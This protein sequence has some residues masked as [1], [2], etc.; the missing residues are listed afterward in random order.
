MSRVAARRPSRRRPARP[1][2][3]TATRQGLGPPGP[4]PARERRETHGLTR[5]G[6][7]ARWYVPDRVGGLVVACGSQGPGHASVE[8]P[9]RHRLI[10]NGIGRRGPGCFPAQVPGHPPGSRRACRRTARERGRGRYP[11][12]PRRHYQLTPRRGRHAANTLRSCQSSGRPWWG[13]PGIEG[14]PGVAPLLLPA[15]STTAR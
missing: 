13:E 6:P 3:T 12:R 8:P 4:G 1:V 2:S 10:A 14:Q 11:H 9:L 7:Y 5:R 15:G